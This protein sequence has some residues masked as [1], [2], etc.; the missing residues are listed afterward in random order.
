MDARYIKKN[1]CTI[2]LAEDE[3]SALF[4]RVSNL[5]YNKYYTDN[6]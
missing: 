1:D 5:Q 4:L 2:N 3:L 6:I